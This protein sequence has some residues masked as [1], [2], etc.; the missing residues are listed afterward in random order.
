MM[1]SWENYLPLRAFEVFMFPVEHELGESCQ[2]GRLP[3]RR[4]P[5]HPPR[6]LEPILGPSTITVTDPRRGAGAG[7]RNPPT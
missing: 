3:R 7:G 1:L 2:E 6:A 5:D 4:R